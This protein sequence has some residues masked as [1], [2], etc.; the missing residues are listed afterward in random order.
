MNAGTGRRPVLTKLGQQ[1]VAEAERALEEAA[2]AAYVDAKRAEFDRA[3][4][5]H[6]ARFGFDIVTGEFL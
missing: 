6:C 5:E 4:D 3:V 1:V 2:S